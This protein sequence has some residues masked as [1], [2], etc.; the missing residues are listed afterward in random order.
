MFPIDAL[1]EEVNRSW[2]LEKNLNRDHP[3]PVCQHHLSI[4][5]YLLLSRRD[6]HRRLDYIQPFI[7]NGRYLFVRREYHLHCFLYLDSGI[8]QR[9]WSS[10][11]I[12]FEETPFESIDPF[13]HGDCWIRGTSY[14]E[15]GREVWVI[16]IEG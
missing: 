9:V 8:L 15:D 5:Q 13:N 14:K 11:A 1:E 16:N 4:A 2:R 7:L 3:I 12:V 6:P 10:D